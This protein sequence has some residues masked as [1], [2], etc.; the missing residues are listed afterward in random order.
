MHVLV[1]IMKE[2]MVARKDSRSFQ[3]LQNSR[4]VSSLNDS[5]YTVSLYM[6]IYIY[7]HTRKCI[8]V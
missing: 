4:M 3:N 8:Y 6:Y 7:I 5:Q 1:K 2:K